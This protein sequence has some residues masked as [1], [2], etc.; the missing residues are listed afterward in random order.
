MSAHRNRVIPRFSLL[1]ALM[2]LAA[3]YSVTVLNTIP[4]LKTVET[5]TVESLIVEEGSFQELF[6]E[7]EYGWPWTYRTGLANSIRDGLDYQAGFFW[8]ALA[9]NIATGMGI[10]LGG[11]GM[12]RDITSCVAPSDIA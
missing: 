12:Y 7:I 5:Q 11:R 2:M 3:L 6:T 10:S 1:T 4:R 8:S 9:L